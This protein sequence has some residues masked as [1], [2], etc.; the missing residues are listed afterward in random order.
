SEGVD[1]QRSARY[2]V[3]GWLPFT[4]KA[5]NATGETMKKM[6]LEQREKL[7]SLKSAIV[8]DGEDT[9]SRARVENA[10]EE[11][12]QMMIEDG[13][14]ARGV[15]RYAY[16][17]APPANIHSIVKDCVRDV[18][19][20][21]G[22]KT[23]SIEEYSLKTNNAIKYKILLSISSRLDNCHLP[24]NG[25]LIYLNTVHDIIDFYSTPVRNTNEYTQ[26][27]RRNDKPSN[28]T[29]IERPFRFHPEDVE[30]FHGGITA[31]PGEGGEVLSLRNKRLYRQFKPKD[32][33]FDYEDQSFDY[34]RVDAKMPWDPEMVERMDSFADKR[35]N[36][37][38][39]K[40]TRTDSTKGLEQQ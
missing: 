23:E 17:Y 34:T 9:Q 16:N 39:R 3:R 29:V 21:E 27:A 32:K 8:V 11:P 10:M 26:L 22:E 1:M 4:K 35:Y 38:T 19:A 15:S 37:S 2:C 24:V 14:R 25:K 31:F 40:F 13:I 30:A 36:L 20:C 18:V 33:W 12:D 5:G 28:L 6:S 7:R